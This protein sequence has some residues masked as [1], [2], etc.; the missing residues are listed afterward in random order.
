MEKPPT[1][2]S[3]EVV[4][5][6]FTPDEEEDVLD[7]EEHQAITEDQELALE[8]IAE[9]D[10]KLRTLDIII[11]SNRLYRERDYPKPTLTADREEI[12]GLEDQ[13]ETTYIEGGEAGELETELSKKRSRYEE[14]VE[15]YSDQKDL[16]FQARP[17]S[18]EEV[19]SPKRLV[20]V[21]EEELSPEMKS[22]L[23]TLEGIG[24]PADEFKDRVSEL[25]GPLH[26]EDRAVHSVLTSFRTELLL[27]KNSERLAFPNE[28]MK[29]SAEL[30]KRM[31]RV[32]KDIPR[33]ADTY[34]LT[35]KIN[36]ADVCEKFDVV[37]LEAIDEYPP[38]V[39]ARYFRFVAVKLAEEAKFAVGNSDV[40]RKLTELGGKMAEFRRYS[41]EAL[42]DRREVEFG[43][44]KIEKVLEY[45]DNEQ[46]YLEECIKAGKQLRVSDK[47][48]DSFYQYNPERPED[49]V[50]RDPVWPAQSYDI[51]SEKRKI[52]DR[53]G[54]SGRAFDHMELWRKTLRQAS[55]EL[56]AAHPF[57]KKVDGL[58]ASHH[59]RNAT[60]RLKAQL[61]IVRAEKEQLD[62]HDRY[63]DD[64]KKTTYELGG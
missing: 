9:I 40:R 37:H 63:L 41:N 48:E 25:V 3:D 39:R 52:E 35:G 62:M 27:Q 30:S 21:S 53:G 36:V 55:A 33:L 51:D 34:R 44:E 43:I 46:K 16:M 54:V 14:G 20:G 2:Q 12:E 60:E 31:P 22:L 58:V 11:A 4:E 45:A 17:R 50:E 29:M 28:L 10:K 5:A 26:Y 59:L 47:V 6:K 49:W 24:L 7:L 8:N 38:E 56:I 1:T 57:D 32:E 23:Q 64:L 19:D 42:A 61:D 13:L 15:F 18:L